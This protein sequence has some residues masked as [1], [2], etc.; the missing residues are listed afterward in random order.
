M[1]ATTTTSPPPACFART[2]LSE[3]FDCECPVCEEERT[4]FDDE[5]PGLPGDRGKPVCLKKDGLHKIFDCECF[6]CRAGR[7]Q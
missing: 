1:S 4:L 2:P 6:R 5:P 3:V 7:F